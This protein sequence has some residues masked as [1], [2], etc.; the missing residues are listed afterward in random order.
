MAQIPFL[1]MQKLH[2]D[3]VKTGSDL[4]VTKDAFYGKKKGTHPHELALKIQIGRRNLNSKVAELRSKFAL[5][6]NPDFKEK[7]EANA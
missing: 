2:K 7:E 4:E 6:I 5:I 3:I 1:T